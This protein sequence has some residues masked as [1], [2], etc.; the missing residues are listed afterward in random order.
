MSLFKA[1]DIEIKRD[2]IYCDKGD[3][4]HEVFE[5]FCT[6]AA[7]PRLTDAKYL[8]PLKY[9]VQHKDTYDAIDVKEVLCAVSKL[10]FLS[11]RKQRIRLWGNKCRLSN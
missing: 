10:R 9:V 11:D 7:L 3:T 8:V 6:F 5:Q 1:K 4:D 2:I